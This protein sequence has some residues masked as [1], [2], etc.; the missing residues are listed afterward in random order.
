MGGP[1]IPGLISRSVER[2]YDGRN[3][4]LEITAAQLL[5][6]TNYVFSEKVTDADE[7]GLRVMAGVS[8]TILANPAEAERFCG[9]TLRGDWAAAAKITA[10][11]AGKSDDPAAGALSHALALLNA[12]ACAADAFAI[13][14]V[15]R[16]K[17]DLAAYHSDRPT[18]IASEQ[19]KYVSNSLTREALIRSTVYA[20]LAWLG[21]SKTFE[22]GLDRDINR[23]RFERFSKVLNSIADNPSSYSKIMSHVVKEDWI[24]ANDTAAQLLKVDRRNRRQPA[25]AG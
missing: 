3:L 17:A 4:L 9:A 1:P 12:P 22:F 14:A 19:V 11:L 13:A 10:L 25:G 15:T 23:R 18:N 5:D 21:N 6:D 20:S 2:A 8:R 16:G 24:A 7:H